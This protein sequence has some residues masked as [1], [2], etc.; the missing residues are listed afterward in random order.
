MTKRRFRI[1]NHKLKFICF[2]V[3]GSSIY[4]ACSRKTDCCVVVNLMASFDIRGSNQISIFDSSNT[5][6]VRQ[7]DIKIYYFN[8]EGRYEL[9]NKSNLD[10]SGGF[11]INH[12]DGSANYVFTV[13]VNDYTEKDTSYTLVDFGANKMDTIKAVIKRHQINKLWW[14][15]SLLSNAQSPVKINIDYP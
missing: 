11:L 14:N 7:D 6:F 8:A 10:L 13:L 3:F 4:F 1:F 5:S 15:D 12:E 2:I 9:V